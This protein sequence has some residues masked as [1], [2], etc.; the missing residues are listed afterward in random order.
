MTERL[1]Q[2]QALHYE[3][4]AIQKPAKPSPKL[5]ELKNEAKQLSGMVW[6]IAAYF[7]DYAIALQNEAL[8]PAVGQKMLKRKPKDTSLR[9]LEQLPNEE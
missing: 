8:A 7:Q 3:A 5:L 1:I 6:D 2:I 4:G 9:T